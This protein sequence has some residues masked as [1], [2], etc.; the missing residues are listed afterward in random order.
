MVTDQQVRRLKSLMQKK[1]LAQAAAEAGMDEK[2]ARKWRDS[3]KL[4]SQCVKP[5]NYRTRPDPF[6]S[7]W[8]E[9]RGVF[10]G[11]PGA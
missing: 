3:E 11:E 10:R 2:T 4:P 8:E 1:T 5:R 9:V 6:A 7:V